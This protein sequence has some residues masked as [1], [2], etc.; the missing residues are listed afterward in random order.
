MPFYTKISSLFPGRLT[1]AQYLMIGYLL[2]TSVGASLLMLPLSSTQGESLS[3]DNALFTITSAISGS[4][5]TPVDIGSYFSSFGEI[6]ILI[7]IQVGNVG[8]MLFFALAV[9]FFGGRL[10]LAN[11]LMIKESISYGSIDI[12]IF[13]KKVF[14]YTVIIE[15]ICA[16]LLT[17]YWT[18]F[19][20][21]L[22]AIK[23]GV[24]HSVSAFC[25]AGFSL[26][27]DNLI[28]YRDSY[29][30]NLVII[31]TCYAGACGFYVLYDISI[32][33]KCFLSKKTRGRLSVHTKTV[34]TVSSLIIITATL[35][36]FIFENNIPSSG[37]DKHFLHSFFQSASASTTVGYNSVDL[38]K[39]NDSSL[40]MLVPVMFIGASPSG[41][42][43]GI[44]TTVFVLMLI[45][46]FTFL[47]DRKN[48]NLFKRNIPS[49]IINK[50]FSI[51]LLAVSWLFL[52][53]LI[54]SIVESHPFINILFECASAFGN[55]GLSTGITPS[56][57]PL[58]KIFLSL[59]MLMG[60]VGPLLV[61]YTI[62][63]TPKP[64][65][66]QYP[67][68]NILIV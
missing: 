64:E 49:T 45:S 28:S 21:L 54:I 63:G 11:R 29:F 46:L 57:T 35:Y 4:G 43:G 44:K 1:R 61:G 50:A 41:T 14:K 52:S 48:I 9:I 25:T 19:F 67:E 6:V 38:G 47:K 30:I 33:T 18:Q 26:F 23:H 39:M 17:L 56:L 53:A 3:L 5:L 22:T 37:I 10:S 15:F 55:V 7:F 2:F 42:G 27:P 12:K 62:F 8:Y 36:L 51:G 59:T 24:F 20:P 60:R 16:V 40:F 65:N 32:Y 66:Y 34:L 31:L 58:S 68:A 13:I